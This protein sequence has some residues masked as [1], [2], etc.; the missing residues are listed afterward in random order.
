MVCVCLSPILLEVGHALSVKDS[1]ILLKLKYKIGVF[2]NLNKTIKKIGLFEN[3]NC[4]LL[5]K[6]N[7]V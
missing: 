5:K 2:E 6:I 1:S 7:F 3:M 4:S